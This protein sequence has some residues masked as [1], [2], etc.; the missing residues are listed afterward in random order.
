MHDRLLDSLVAL[1][2]RWTKTLAL[3]KLRGFENQ[4]YLEADK[5]VDAA[6]GVVYKVYSYGVRTHIEVGIPRILHYVYYMIHGRAPEGRLTDELVAQHAR[7]MEAD[8]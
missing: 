3:E 2:E 4:L 7:L 8:E 5:N 1:D 6:T